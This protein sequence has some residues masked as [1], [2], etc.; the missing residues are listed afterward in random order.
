MVV[1]GGETAAFHSLAREGHFRLTSLLMPALLKSPDARVVS[2]SS[3][4]HQFASTVEWDDLNAQAP[5]AY[6]PWKAYG[7][8]KLSN[9]Y[10]TKALQSRVDS[11]GGAGCLLLA[12]METKKGLC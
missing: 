11:K 4:A 6:A 2:V 1:H 10:F 12:A 9:I 5:D 3:S 8:S 7:L